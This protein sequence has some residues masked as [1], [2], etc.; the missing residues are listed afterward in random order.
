[1]S[2]SFVFILIILQLN[3]IILLNINNDIEKSS[4]DKAENPSS[5]RINQI[6]ILESRIPIGK[7]FLLFFACLVISILYT[8][9][10]NTIIMN[11]LIKE[12]FSI[13]KNNFEFEELD[14]AEL[15]RVVI[16]HIFPF[17]SKVYY[18]KGL[19]ILP[20][21]TLNI[22]LVQ[23]VTFN[24]NPFEKDLPQMTVDIIYIFG[25]RT[26]IFEIYDLMIDKKNIKFKN[27]LQ[28]IN[29]IKETISDF[30]P[31]ITKKPWYEHHLAA[32]IK[33]CGTVDD[34]NKI[35]NFFKDAVNAYIDFAKDAPLLNDNDKEKKYF[36][37]KGLSD[38]FVKN[39][40]VSVSIFKKVLGVEKT[41]EFLGRIIFGYLHIKD[42]NLKI[43]KNSLVQEGENGK[44]TNLEEDKNLI[45]NNK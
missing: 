7:I 14:I 24:I 20:V 38:E 36:L 22:G 12:G 5:K 34:E 4:I 10:R 16:Y 43:Y 2:K 42:L 32:N 45:Q 29:Q 23:M 19:G 41:R 37:V 8:A 26:I 25:K 21:M 31:Y 28:K 15:R 39:G 6:K 11:K 40:G 33:K 3:N 44:N 18:I 17:Y 27:Y 30:K 13:V 35:L 1:M 9:I